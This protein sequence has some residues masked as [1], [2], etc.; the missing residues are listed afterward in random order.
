MLAETGWHWEASSPEFRAVSS[1]LQCRCAGVLIKRPAIPTTARIGTPGEGARP[2]GWHPCAS[3]R[4]GALTRRGSRRSK[5]KLLSSGLPKPLRAFI[6]D[7]MNNRIG[8]VVLIIL[9]LGL[10]VAVLLVKK[11]AAEQHTEDSKQI[12][13]V[14][15]H[16]VKANTDF[17]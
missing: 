4:P 17:E 1:W 16:L 2:T 10:G 12:E 13:T 6:F 7:N 11:G 3:C 5:R 8:V 15:N 14:S 9:C